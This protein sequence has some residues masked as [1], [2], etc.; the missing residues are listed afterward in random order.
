MLGRQTQP[1]STNKQLQLYAC[2]IP[3]KG[4][5]DFTLGD[6]L[7]VSGLHPMLYVQSEPSERT[8]QANV[9]EML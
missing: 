3:P 2:A 1:Q 4:R 8:E 6:A 9:H 7:E 5:P